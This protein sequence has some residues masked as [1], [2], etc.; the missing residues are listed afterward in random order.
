MK[1]QGK[2]R[3]VGLSNVSVEQIEQARRIVPIA[4]V[5]NRYNLGDRQHEPVLRH[6]AAEGIGF[7]PWY[8]L[9][10]GDL[11]SDTGVVGRIARKHGATPAQ[12]ALAWLLG[13]AGG[14][15]APHPRDRLGRAPRGERRGGGAHPRRGRSAGARRLLISR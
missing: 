1:E 14:G 10:T 2:V 11:A 7:I 6:C 3:H 5:Q 8:P 4:T 9:A 12:V 13:R 15:G